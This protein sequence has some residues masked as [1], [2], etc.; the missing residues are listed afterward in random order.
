MTDEDL[1]RPIRPRASEPPS[2]R[3]GDYRGARIGATAALVIVTVFLLVADALNTEYEMNPVV[4]ILLLTTI[5][6]LLG[7]EARDVF[8]GPRL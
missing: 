7:L 6:T 2:G 3:R 1:E 5:L 8:W 4:L